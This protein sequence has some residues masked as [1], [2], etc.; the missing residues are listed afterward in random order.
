VHPRCSNS[1]SF[2]GVKR[3]CLGPCQ[4]SRGAPAAQV[5]RAC[6]GPGNPSAGLNWE[7]L[8][9]IVSAGM[10]RYANFA[11]GDARHVKHCLWRLV[12]RL[13][14]LGVLASL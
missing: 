10:Q 9:T 1:D 6:P 3:K 2:L 8:I 4:G 7:A 11:C 13:L 14:G 12:T 5:V